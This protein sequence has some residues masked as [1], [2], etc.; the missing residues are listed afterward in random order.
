MSLHLIKR[1]CCTHVNC[2]ALAVQSPHHVAG[3]DGL[4]AAQLDDSADVLF[5]SKRY[6]SASDSNILFGNS[7]HT[8]AHNNLEEAPEFEACLFVDR[9]RDA[10]DAAAAR[11]A[12]NVRLADAVDVVSEDLS[13]RTSVCHC[14][15]EL[16]G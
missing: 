13:R 3:A 7:L 5:K 16:L 15:L 10:L 11:H 14:R 2:A 4:A 9:S 6:R 12:T 8:Y 1:L